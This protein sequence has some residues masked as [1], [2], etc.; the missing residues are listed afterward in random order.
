MRPP[1]WVNEQAARENELRGFY[2]GIRDGDIKGL[3][4]AFNRIGCIHVGASKNLMVNILRK[5][6]GWKGFMMTDS[7]KSAS[8]FLPKETAAA[9]N[10]QMLG[11]SNN[12]KI[13]NLSEAE[14]LKD[15]VF[16]SN[17]RESYHRKLY[18]HVNSNLMNGITAD[19]TAKNA[20]PVWVTILMI[21]MGIGYAGFGVFLVLYLLNNRKERR[22]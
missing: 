12:G 21:L 9:G 7:V 14:V 11:G 8:Y 5:E 3:M 19:T 20:Q 1:A 18:A 4:S 15:I 10:D 17:I 22:A 6:W 16:Q 13:W 2:I